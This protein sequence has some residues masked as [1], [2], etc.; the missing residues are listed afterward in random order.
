MTKRELMQVRSLQAEIRLLEAEEKRL[1]EL[2]TERVPP[3][4]VKGSEAEYPYTMHTIMMDGGV[5][6]RTGGDSDALKIQ[7]DKL[8]GKLT[9][10][11]LDYSR[12]YERVFDWIRTIADSRTRLIFELRYLGG[13]SWQQIANAFGNEMS[14]DAMRMWHDRFAKKFL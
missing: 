14:G 10:C 12:A 6:E 8:A 1:N 9:K 2:L 7:R 5:R 4:C 13:K 3:T 11:K